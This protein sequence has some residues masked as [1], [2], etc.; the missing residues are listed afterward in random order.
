MD[1]GDYSEWCG[2]EQRLRQRCVISPL[3]L[4]L[5][6]A[7]VKTVTVHRFSADAAIMAD[8]AYLGG[9]VPQEGGGVRRKR[10]Q[11]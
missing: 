11:R 9:D 5:F 10:P 2:V 3:L 1:N 8:L 7:A 4:K 6:F